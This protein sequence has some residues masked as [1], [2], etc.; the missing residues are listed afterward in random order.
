[1]KQKKSP[2]TELICPDCWHFEVR[3]EKKCLCGGENSIPARTP[4][5]MSFLMSAYAWTRKRL[6]N[7]RIQIDVDG[8]FH[9]LDKYIMYSNGPVHSG[10]GDG[11]STIH[12]N[13]YEYYTS[14]LKNIGVEIHT[15]G[16]VVI[17]GEEFN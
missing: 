3:E 8:S 4:R 7:G 15:N 1:M 16:K 6:P 17:N 14:S 2:M 10:R 11:P 5:G 9:Y 13:G 12:A